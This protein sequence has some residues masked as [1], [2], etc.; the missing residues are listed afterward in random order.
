MEG[1]KFNKL[2][3][4]A[5]IFGSAAAAAVATGE[6]F[7]HQ[8]GLDGNA[9]HND[10]PHPPEKK[11]ESIPTNLDFLNV[12][13]DPRPYVTGDL[14]GAKFGNLL[15]MYT[16]VSQHVPGFALVDFKERLG[17]LWKQKL[18]RAKGKGDAFPPEMLKVAK[19]LFDSYDIDKSPKSTMQSYRAEID[20]SIRE[21]RKSIELDNLRKTRAFADLT[22]D[23]LRLLKML[24]QKVTATSLLAYSVTEL[25]PTEGSD[26]PI[27]IEIYEFLLRNAGSAFVDRI[28]A[29]GDNFISF[30]PYQFTSHALKEAGDVAEG[31][32]YMHRHLSKDKNNRQIPAT[33]TQLRGNGHHKA[34]YLFGLYNL[35]LGVRGLSD[36]QAKSLAMDSKWVTDRDVV[37]FI[38]AAHNLPSVSYRSFQAYVDAYTK[39]KKAGKKMEDTLINFIQ[40]RSNVAGPYASKTATN[41]E[42]LKKRFG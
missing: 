4:R 32:S 6:H 20:T 39:N 13:E 38:S 35:A 28:P 8:T 24:D 42:L 23:H 15:T 3:R 29:L 21:V 2:S 22:D 18:L 33:V 11:P 37:A 31:A 25:M 1:K 5:L 10:V 41:Y 14:Q 40:T 30:G 27:G 9:P 34:A 7:L 36:A 26:A 19:T 17:N 12:I 16:G